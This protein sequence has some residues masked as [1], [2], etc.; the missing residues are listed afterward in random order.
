MENLILALFDSP[1]Y[2]HRSTQ[3]SPASR[4]SSNTLALVPFNASFCETQLPVS[5]SEHTMRPDASTFEALNTSNLQVEQHPASESRSVSSLNSAE[6]SV[7]NTSLASGTPSSTVQMGNASKPMASAF[8]SSKPFIPRSYGG[9]L[10][11]LSSGPVFPST[12]I[13]PVKSVS[14]AFPD[15]SSNRAF[16]LP[17]RFVP[18]TDA[19]LDQSATTLTPAYGNRIVSL[20]ES[21]TFPNKLI[22][23]SLPSSHH[24]R[25]DDTRPLID[26]SSPQPKHITLSSAQS[27]PN[28]SI[29]IHS[30]FDKSSSRSPSPSSTHEYSQ[31][32]SESIIFVNNPFVG[33]SPSFL[34]RPQSPAS[35]VVEDAPSPAKARLVKL[36]SSQSAQQGDCCHN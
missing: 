24:P 17:V 31:S 4:S 35:R 15:G 3:T 16:S 23:S 6:L 28:G 7:P 33:R 30:S 20:P 10:A 25:D 2:I 9:D 27:S 11:P 29:L 26:L 1:L 8:Q 5:L 19:S 12:R 13:H 22:V 36:T 32:E 18:G 34:R 14:V 21:T